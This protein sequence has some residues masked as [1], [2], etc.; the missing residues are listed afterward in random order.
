MSSRTANNRRQFEDRETG[1]N[2]PVLILAAI[3]L[4]GLARGLVVVV[5]VLRLLPAIVQIVSPAFADSL[6][7]GSRLYSLVTQMDFLNVNTLV[8]SLIGG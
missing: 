5:L 4:F 3:A 7:T 6:R 1:S 2:A 8:T